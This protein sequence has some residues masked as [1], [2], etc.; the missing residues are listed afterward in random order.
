M[1]RQ[2]NIALAGASASFLAAANKGKPLPS[3][4]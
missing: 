4:R 2:A 1:G 3:R